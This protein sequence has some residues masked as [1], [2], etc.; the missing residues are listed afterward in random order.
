LSRYFSAKFVVAY[1][2][3]LLVA[4]TAIL[5]V[6]LGANDTEVVVN[7]NSNNANSVNKSLSI[8]LFSIDRT[9]Q[10]VGTPDIAAEVSKMLVTLDGYILQP[11]KV[12]S[13]NEWYSSQQLN[14]SN[15]AKS[16]LASIIYEVAVRTGMEVGERYTHLTLPKFTNPGFDVEILDEQKN[17]SIRNPYRYSFQFQN[18]DVASTQAVNVLTNAKSVQLPLISLDNKTLPFEKVLL[19]DKR[20]GGTDLPAGAVNGAI[21]KVFSVM[22][23][24][25]KQ[26]VSRDYYPSQ[27]QIVLKGAGADSS[28]D[29]SEQVAP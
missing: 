14:S 8:K 4:G 9:Q 12:F 16:A 10:L 20:G 18:T 29:E 26:L 5:F 2:I 21:I 1:L 25:E 17:M 15:N 6:F 24:Q 28:A 11:N 22:G 13:F 27:A 23:G 19:A 7:K 3:V